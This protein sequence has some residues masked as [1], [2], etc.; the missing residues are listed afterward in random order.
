MTFRTEV[1]RQAYLLREETNR[2]FSECL[3]VSWKLYRL[4]KKLEAGIVTFSYRKLD[5][6]IRRARGTLKDTG[7]IPKGKEISLKVINYFDI[8][9]K[10]YR[11]FRI[12][13]LIRVYTS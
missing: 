9:A 4:R 3:V 6:S 13:N 8:D 10:E 2:P 1:F 11:S 7:Y 12:S 5:G